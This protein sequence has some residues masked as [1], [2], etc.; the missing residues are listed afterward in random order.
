MQNHPE[1]AWNL[2]LL[3]EA[4]QRLGFTDGLFGLSLAAFGSVSGADPLHWCNRSPYLFVP[5]QRFEPRLA[6]V[7]REPGEQCFFH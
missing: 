6:E 1:P 2:E 4:L 5:S 7:P 3:P